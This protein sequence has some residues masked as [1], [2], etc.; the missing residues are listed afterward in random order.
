MNRPLTPELERNL[1]EFQI[2]YGNLWREELLKFNLG[3]PSSRGMH[4]LGPMRVIRNYHC[5]NPSQLP[6]LR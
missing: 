6:D 1:K 2:L 4:L 3:E 5:P